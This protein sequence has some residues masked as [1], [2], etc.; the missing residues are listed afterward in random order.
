MD[1]L[2]TDWGNLIFDSTL[3]GIGAPIVC[4][5]HEVAMLTKDAHGTMWK[6]DGNIAKNAL[7]DNFRGTIKMGI[8]AAVAF[9][10]VSWVSKVSAKE[11]NVQQ[12]Q[13]ANRTR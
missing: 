8:V 12:A 4:K 9:A 2:V 6:W 7:Q 3:V 1:A 10:A 13:P 11:Q 5:A